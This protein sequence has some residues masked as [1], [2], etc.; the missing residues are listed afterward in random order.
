MIPKYVWFGTAFLIGLLAD[1]VSKYWIIDSLHY[2]ERMWVAPGLLEL[3]HVRNPG[4]IFSFLADGSV[5][6]RMIV[7]VGAALVAS[8]LLI[9]FLI[10]H[11]AEERLSP[12]ALGLILAGAVGNLADRLIHG[13]VIDFLNVHLWG[14]Y[15][16]PTFNI[17]DSLIVVG[18]GILMLML[19]LGDE[20]EQE[21]HG[22][23][24]ER[25]HSGG[26]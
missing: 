19:F 25:A 22:N 4:G 6:L 7:F 26:G 18:T 20:P 2:G 11:E 21:E 23:I 1:Q 8:V 16:W 9:V 15:V 12:L 13:E 24:S 14:G 17:A 5:E 3:T 10:R